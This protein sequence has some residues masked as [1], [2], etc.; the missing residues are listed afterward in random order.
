MAYWKWSMIFIESLDCES[1]LRR[2]RRVCRTH[3]RISEKDLAR[4]GWSISEARLRLRVRHVG[5]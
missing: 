3:L 1:D 4:E 2:V 5:P